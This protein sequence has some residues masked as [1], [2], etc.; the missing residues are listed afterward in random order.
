MGA[1]FCYV[2]LDLEKVAARICSSKGGKQR[3]SCAGSKAG[4]KTAATVTC[5]R[6]DSVKGLAVKLLLTRT[7]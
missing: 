2:L 4:S 7:D 1:G 6:I 5:L 3:I